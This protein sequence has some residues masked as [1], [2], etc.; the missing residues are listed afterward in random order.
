[1]IGGDFRGEKILKNKIIGST[2][3]VLA[4]IFLAGCSNNNQKDQ[5]TA[6][7][8][9]TK[10]TYHKQSIVGYYK[11]NDTALNLRSDGTGQYVHRSNDGDTNDQLTWKKNGSAYI[12]KLEDN[13]GEISLKGKIENNKFVLSGENWTTQ[14]LKKVSGRINM[15]SFLGSDE[16]NTTEDNSS[17]ENS[18]S[19]SSSSNAK[20]ES[21]SS[22][23]KKS[24][25]VA[26]DAGSVSV[27]SE[28]IGTWYSA[29]A[30]ANNSKDGSKVVQITFTSTGINNGPGTTTFTFHKMKDG[31]DVD[32][33]KDDSD[34]QDQTKDWYVADT[35]KLDLPG[36]ASLGL[37][38][39]K[40]GYNPGEDGSTYYASTDDG[41]KVVA[42]GNGKDAQLAAVYWQ[43]PQLAKKYAGNEARAKLGQ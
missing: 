20:S 8:T 16:V 28:L 13:E 25:E 6:P 37:E 19:E 4:L 39:A 18:D 17:K 14:E 40:W 10:V 32:K 34:Y 27:P 12:I 7:K 41:H 5:N 26:G 38:I 21:K 42:M 22:S 9:S 33:Y 1:M 11:N 30:A 15:D 2:A 24:D 23:E 29:D 36:I 31:F 3:A 35:K 43:T